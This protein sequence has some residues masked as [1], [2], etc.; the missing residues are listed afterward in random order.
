MA[1]KFTYLSS[2]DLNHSQLIE[3][4]GKDVLVISYRVFMAQCLPKAL[5]RGKMVHA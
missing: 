3:R 2:I 1:I 5:Q 4:E